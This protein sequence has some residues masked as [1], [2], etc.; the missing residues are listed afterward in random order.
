MNR[1]DDSLGDTVVAPS[2]VCHVQ[3]PSYKKKKD[4]DNEHIINKF[5]KKKALNNK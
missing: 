3:K 2:S 5:K 1:K 4:M